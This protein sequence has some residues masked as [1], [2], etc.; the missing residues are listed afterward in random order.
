MFHTDPQG[1]AATLR[2]LEAMPHRIILPG[3]GPLLR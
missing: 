1:A 2:V 3:H